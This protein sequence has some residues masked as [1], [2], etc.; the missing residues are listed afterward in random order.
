MEYM[1]LTGNRPGA[2]L[3]L[4]IASLHDFARA[5]ALRLDEISAARPVRMPAVPVFN[6]NGMHGYD[7][8]SR[9]VFSCILSDA[10]VSSRS[11]IILAEG[12]ALIDYQGDELRKHPL[13]LAVDPILFAPRDGH[14]VFAIEGGAFD[15]PP[16]EEAFT[17]VGVNCF[18]YWHWHVEFL[19][20]LMACMDLP[21]FAE[22]PIL[23]DAQMPEQAMVA[24]RFLI[25]DRHRVRV[26]APGEAVRV[27]RL[28]TCAMFAYIPL[29]PLAGVAYPPRTM[30]MDADAFVARIARMGPA[31][32][33]LHE[34]R[35]TRRL[36]LQRGASQHRGM[37]NKTEVDAW[38]AANGFEMVDFG[39]H[40]Y[41]DQLR[42]VREAAII[43]GPNGAAL[44]NSLFAGPGTGI[45]IM[46][47]TFLDDNEWYAAVSGHL[48]QRLSF[49]VGDV[50]DADPLYEFN[51]NYRIDLDLLPAFVAHLEGAAT[52]SS[53]LPSAPKPVADRGPRQW[54]LLFNC[55][56][57]GL[58][59][60]LSL[61][62]ND[63]EVE[64]H[65]TLTIGDNR[66]AILDSLDRYDRILVAPAIEN[67]FELELGNRDNV[68]RLPNLHFAAFHPDACI[69]AQEGEL[70]TGP[71]GLYHSALAYAAF[72]AG[73]DEHRTAGVF[74]EAS[75]LALGY[76]ERWTSDRDPLLATFRNG[77]FDIAQAF[78]GWTRRGCFMHTPNRPRIECLMDVARVVL[79][80]AGLPAAESAHMPVD[81][82]AN[83]P[84][85]PVYPEIAARLGVSGS[86]WFKEEQ[87]CAQME[88]AQYIAGCFAVYRRCDD[89]EATWPSFR[90]VIDKALA[91]VETL[92]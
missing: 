32:Q 80:R 40:A 65:D 57:P 74:S 87:R 49:L 45:G 25:G 55:Q 79:A 38:F 17:L 48:G 4:P 54:L 67:L 70:S 34:G 31:L 50:V 51:A 84:I 71:L 91:F 60:C 7:A 85:F 75:Y 11:N 20:R 28:W 1:R 2:A 90:G 59:N 16:M 61:L 78:M 58:A 64:Y 69:L 15:G 23:V 81:N 30:V 46:D 18:N 68:W 33:R 27:K 83:G 12:A 13:D 9:E 88:L 22:V 62:S 26:L 92:R 89:I 39:A 36:Y 24:L 41:E 82:L 86:H 52:D 5:K 77:G 35:G 76:F 53:A 66:Q 10:V 19:P 47:N 14:A 63:I 44:I 56:A 3:R 73:M 37:V 21:G 6:R 43:V 72:R 29:W 8:V 42:L